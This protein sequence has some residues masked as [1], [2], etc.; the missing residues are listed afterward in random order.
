MQ[1]L[2]IGGVQIK[3]IYQNSV[4][5]KRVYKGSEL[6]WVADPYQPGT[7]LTDVAGANTYSVWLPAGIYKLI[8]TGGGGNGTDFWTGAGFMNAGGGSG[9]TWEG[10]FE[11]P[12][13][14]QLTLY[15]GSGAQDSYMDLGGV[16]M[17]TAGQGGSHSGN[18]AGGAGV[19]SVNG[20]LR[21]V[22][23][24]NV[25]HGNPGKRTGSYAGG[26]SVSSRGWGRGGS[27]LGGEAGGM[28]LQYL[29]V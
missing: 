10:E 17:I 24:S 12:S 11:N 18:S 4:P 16:R 26:D 22:S 19:V 1:K 29:R 25:R 9:A 23:A 13:D 2:Y 3:K 20:S 5:V 21:V 7:V 14:Q 6:V 28:Y 8:L 15:A 27:H